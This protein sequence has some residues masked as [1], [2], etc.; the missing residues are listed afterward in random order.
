MHCL[1]PPGP[2]FFTLSFNVFISLSLRNFNYSAP[3]LVFVTSPHCPTFSLGLLVF[4]ILEV[5]SPTTSSTFPCLF[6]SSAH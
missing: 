3:F 4:P 1:V 5:K 6:Y 2:G